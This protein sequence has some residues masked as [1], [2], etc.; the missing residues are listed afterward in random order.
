VIAKLVAGRAK[1]MEFAELLIAARLVDSAVLS[2]RA[3]LLDRPRA[4]INGVLDRISISVRRAG[5]HNVEDDDSE[6]R[7]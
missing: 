5:E 4:V 1:D 7:T 2:E 6:Q 3:E